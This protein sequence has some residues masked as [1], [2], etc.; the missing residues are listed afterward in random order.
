MLMV[1]RVVNN[2]NNFAVS[3][4]HEG[5]ETFVFGQYV[6]IREVMETIENHRKAQEQEKQKQLKELMG[7]KI[8]HTG[9]ALR[10]GYGTPLVDYAHNEYSRGFAEQAPDVASSTRPTDDEIPF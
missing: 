10:A 9:A 1:N 3:L 4:A 2:E 7:D 6:S 8:L 5:G